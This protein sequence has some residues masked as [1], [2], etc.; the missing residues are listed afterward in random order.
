MDWL[1][2][3]RFKKLSLQEQT[4]PSYGFKKA[5][6]WKV[7]CM[8]WLCFCLGL[9]FASTQVMGMTFTHGNGLLFFVLNHH[10]VAV[11]EK[12]NQVAWKIGNN[13][14]GPI[15]F[16]RNQI[17][18]FTSDHRLNSLNFLNGKLNWNIQLTDFSID[19]SK[20]DFY[21]IEVKIYKDFLI[22]YGEKR[23][24]IIN[25]TKRSVLIDL[26]TKYDKSYN[27]HKIHN[28]IFIVDTTESGAITQ[29]KTEGYKIVTGEKLWEVDSG[30]S[31]ADFNRY[32]FFI[33]GQ[34]LFNADAADEESVE[35]MD[36]ETGISRQIYYEKA[37]K[38][39]IT[40]FPG[41][42][43]RPRCGRAVG[44]DKG[45][46]VDKHYFWVK[47]KDQCG[48]FFWQFEWTKNPVPAPKIIPIP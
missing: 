11:R 18:V 26:L 41:F 22:Y 40:D 42:L 29:F 1:T 9:S 7:F 37:E 45:F 35:L 32:L 46:R 31:I 36:V 3:Y 2:F 48:F 43:I 44:I 25:F 30:S 12:T 20:S 21:N 19:S 14:L 4:K 16:S 13:F 5:I 17:F 34:K 33:H 6:T 27:F 28:G 15:V 39:P 47:R 38:A 8:T 10:I 23:F 24:S